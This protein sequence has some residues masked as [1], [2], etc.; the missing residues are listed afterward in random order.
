MG[1][2]V[3]DDVSL[4]AVADAIRAKGDTTEPLAFPDGFVDA[5]GVLRDD[6]Y[7]ASIIDRSV[8]SVENSRVKT[9]GDYAFYNHPSIKEI[10]LPKT[11]KIGMFFCYNCKTLESVSFPLLTDAGYRTF[12][13]CSALRNANFPLLVTVPQEMFCECTAL[14]NVVISSA[15][16]LAMYVFKKCSSLVKIDMPKVTDVSQDV[17]DKC[18]ALTTCIFRSNTLVANRTSGIFDGT[19][20]AN[21]TGYIY[22]PSALVDSYKTA[23]NWSTYAAQ[24]R[25]IEDYPEITGG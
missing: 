8:T 19:P 16:T 18:S 24:I 7:I 3:V 15:E 9:V 14:E 2:R 4:T 13:G 17:F 5:I 25:A 1:K 23:S 6:E 21:G 20:I 12:Y 10:S 11:T 22:V